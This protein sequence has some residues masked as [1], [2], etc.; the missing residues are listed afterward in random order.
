M[1]RFM[2]QDTKPW[3]AV[4]NMDAPWH[5]TNDDVQGLT[6]GIQEPILESNSP[7]NMP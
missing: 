3:T 5:T 6:K 2:C 1:P 7:V 4:S